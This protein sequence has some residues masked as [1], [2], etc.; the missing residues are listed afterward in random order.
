MH[1]SRLNPYKTYAG[2]IFAL[3][4]LT[5]HCKINEKSTLF[6]ILDLIKATTGL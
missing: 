4:E 3:F 6:G 5:H 1:K 2:Y